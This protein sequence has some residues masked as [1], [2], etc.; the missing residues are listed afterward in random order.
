MV[1]D[2]IKYLRVSETAE[3]LG[4]TTQ[5]VYR[6]TGRGTLSHFRP[7]PRFVLIPEHEVEARRGHG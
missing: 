3:R 6:L 1:I 2:G 5:A 4:V 7:W